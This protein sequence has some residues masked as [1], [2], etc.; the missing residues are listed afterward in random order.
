MIEYKLPAPVV[1]KYAGSETIEVKRKNRR[2]KSFRVQE[3]VE[4]LKVSKGLKAVAAR[5]VGCSY[6]QMRHFCETNASIKAE[7]EAQLEAVLDTAQLQVI[8]AASRGDMGACM[9]LLKTLGRS[10]GFSERTEVTGK[11]GGA[12]EHTHIH[13]WEEK[14]QAVH[15]EMAAR[16]AAIQLERT[17]GGGYARPVDTA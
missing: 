7:C 8:A 11:D 12:I 16:K 4:A 1:D 17:A 6:A 2:A 5:Q 3:I 15:E 14:L 13:L 9:F 10:R